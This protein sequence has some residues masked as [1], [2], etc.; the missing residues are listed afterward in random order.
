M[1]ALLTTVFLAGLAAA[2]GYWWLRR[3]EAPAPPAPQLRLPEGG[4][5]ITLVQRHDADVPGTEG[6]LRV[7]IGDITR[8][9][10]E[11]TMS[12]ADGTLV[13]PVRSVKEGDR[14]E[15]PFAGRVYRL[16][17][18]SFD[19]KLIG[20]DSVVLEFTEGL[21]ETERIESLLKAIEESKLVFIRNGSEH[22]GPAAAAHLRRKLN[23][24]D[25]RVHTVREFIDGI[26]TKSSMSGE[27]YQVRLADGTVSDLAP[28]LEARLK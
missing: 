23:A 10:T 26:A 3:E 28:W 25:D 15:F 18:L 6:A 2:A 8:G 1:R 12:N 4:A 27:P 16:G 11:L 14:I 22:D 13:L 17:V 9:Q 20:D 7:H 21:S 19:T 5:R 24:A